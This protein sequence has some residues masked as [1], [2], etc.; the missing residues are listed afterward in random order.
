MNKVLII[1][2]AG[3]NHNGDMSIAKKLIDIA[4]EAGAD[5]VKFQ[6]FRA[7]ELV[8]LSAQKAEYQSKNTGNSDSQYTMLKQLEMSTENLKMLIEYARSKN[9]KCISTPFSES[10][11]EEIAPLM[12][13][14]KIP[15]GEITNYPFLR[16]LAS[17]NKPIVLST[18]MSTLGEVESAIRE[19]ETV[20]KDKKPIPVIINDKIISP[21][22][23]LHCVSNYPASFESINLRAIQTMHQAFSLPVG[24]SDHTLGIDISI[25]AV[26]MGATLIEK[27]FTLDK[28]LKGPDHLASL[29]PGELKSMV[30]S[31]RNIES[32]L[33]NGIKKPHLSELKNLNVVRK[34]IHIKRAMPK[35]HILDTEDLVLKRPSGGLGA[36]WLPYIIGKKLKTDATADY[37]LQLSNIEL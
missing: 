32:A 22:T 31:I 27:H 16:F 25:A 28:N 5:V 10:V 21:L 11:A 12:P 7:D 15:S 13:F 36:E 18:G 29:E 1:A 26:A 6:S 24:Y 20:W 37:M 17:Y 33:G 2:E 3:V 30:H 8:T 35:G 19:I 14:W 23:I 34:S 4:S 9:I